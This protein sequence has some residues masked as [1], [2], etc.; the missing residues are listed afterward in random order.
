MCICCLGNKQKGYSPNRNNEKKKF[1]I[2][3]KRNDKKTKSIKIECFSS[4]I[5]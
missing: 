4:V 2:E 3:N 1:K 5:F